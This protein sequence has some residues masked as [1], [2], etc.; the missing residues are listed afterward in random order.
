MKLL[1]ACAAALRLAFFLLFF[2]WL[3]AGLPVGWPNLGL[4]LAAQEAQAAPSSYVYDDAGR[5]IAVIDPA[6]ETATYTYDAVGNLLAISRQSSA[7]L[8]LLNFTPKSGPI[9]TV[10]TIYGTG[11][12]TTA[13]QNTVTFNGTV[14]TVTS[15]TTTQI[16]TSVPAG[17]TTGPIT[18]TTP[19]GSVTSS[20]VFTVTDSGPALGA[21]T[22]SSFTPTIGSPGATVTIT[23]T[24]FDSTPANNEVA[25]NVTQSTVSASTSTSLTTSVPPSGTS[26]RI[27]VATMAGTAVS[28]EDFFVP[29]P[30]YTASDVAF[31]DRMAIG[32]SKTVT[33]S[34]ANKIGLVVFD[35]TAGQR[36][37]LNM[38]NVTIGSGPCCATKVTVSINDPYGTTQ[39]TK[40]VPTT[41]A[42]L[43]PWTLPLTGTYT[44]LVD[45]TDTNTG[46]VTLTLYE[47]PLDII[48]TITPGGPSVTVTIATPGQNAR[49]T[50]TGTAGQ[51]V[52]LLINASTIAAC[53]LNLLQPDG[54]TLDTMGCRSS[55][56]FME[57]QTLPVNGTYTVLIDPTGAN[58]GQVTLTLY[59][60]PPDVTGPITPGGPA[61]TVTL[62]TPGQN[63]RLTF[64]GTAGQRV[65]ILINT[66]TITSCS[67]GSLILRRPDGSQVSTGGVC[68]GTFLD[69][70]TLPTTGTYT[71]VLDPSGTNT[72]Q[73]TVTLYDVADVTG[74]ITPGGPSMTVTITTPG[75]SGRLSFDGTA[76]QRV[77]V[78][79]NNATFASCGSV[80]I[81]KP[82][83]TTL[84][85]GSG[86]TNSFID[87]QTLPVTGTYTLLIDPYGTNTGQST[88]TLYD[89]P[90]DVSGSLTIGGTAVTVTIST[91]GQNGQ[92]TFAGTA[93]QQV[94]VRVTNNTIGT[95]T[96]K[97]LKPD[98]SVMVSTTS[99]S[100]SFNQATQTL[101]TT[102]TYTVVID[103]S[104]TRTGSLSARVTSP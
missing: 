11:F 31:T 10:V 30:P 21:P 39:A 14:A 71:I 42:F 45:P 38:T 12:S 73:A 35:G 1:F 54:T 7:L 27:M 89:V 99:S 56:T 36:I 65:S 23:G 90:P 50:F 44:I 8:S 96:V 77:S 69:T 98:G 63:A 32:Q 64:T 2:P 68:T 53:T 34:T 49:L 5:L 20:V 92:L 9:G 46:S 58:T 28:G 67:T 79:V 29:L 60:V 59:D 25:F 4:L 83:G 24:N 75:Q 48:G 80:K 47:V 74:S 81:L 94:T 86:C 101:P 19:N 104:G 85:S 22:I 26:G 76:G 95:V 37:S 97:L 61:V 93:G 70:Q 100:S 52:S 40:D 3:F 103:P 82:D 6:G 51:R 84:A 72:G 78:L 87:V 102:G 41:G 18:V 88:L 16:V 33:I 15:A 43:E 55:G 17:A 62:T 66:S 57:P 13:S 91:P